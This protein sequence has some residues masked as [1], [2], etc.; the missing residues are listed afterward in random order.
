MKDGR[1]FSKALNQNVWVHKMVL[2]GK[3]PYC[4]CEKCGKPLYTGFYSVTLEQDGTEGLYG[5]ECIKK[6][7]LIKG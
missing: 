6:L 4:E 3:F 7:N 5:S 2:D 1:Y